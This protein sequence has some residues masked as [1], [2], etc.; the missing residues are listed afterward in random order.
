MNNVLL[1]AIDSDILYSGSL[2]SDRMQYKSGGVVTTG[3]TGEASSYKAGGE[4]ITLPNIPPPPPGG[5]VSLPKPEDI[6]VPVPTE[7]P[8]EQPTGSGRKNMLLYG[9][10]AVV[11]AYLLFRKK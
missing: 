3:P 5:V 9:I 2:P 10:G 6:A 4:L 7:T 11:L 8:T 1:G